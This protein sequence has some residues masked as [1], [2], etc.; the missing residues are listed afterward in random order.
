MKFQILSAFSVHVGPYRTYRLL[1]TGP[2]FILYN[3]VLKSPVLELSKQEFSIKFRN[4]HKM[5]V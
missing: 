3:W 5:K 1:F 2:S 4:A